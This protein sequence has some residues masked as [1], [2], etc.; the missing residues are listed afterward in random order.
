MLGYKRFIEA[1]VMGNHKCVARKGYKLFQN[2]VRIGC[3]FDVFLMDTC[4]MNDVLGYILPGIDEGNIPIDDFPP[5]EACCCY[6]DKLVMIKGKTR[7]LCVD[8][9]DIPIEHPEI[10]LLRQIR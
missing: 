7:R 1:Y 6:L 5:I 8:Y 3:V 4:Q 10:E 2:L 9:D